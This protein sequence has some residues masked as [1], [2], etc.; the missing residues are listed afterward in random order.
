MRH[1]QQCNE[2]PLS[3]WIICQR[4]GEICCAH[5]NC[6]AG[7][8]EVCTH[9]AAV[10]F[11]LE[12]STRLNERNT[13]TQEKC[14]WV[15]PGFQKE[16]PYSPVKAIDFTSARGKKTK[17]DSVL[18]MA[19]EP[20]QMPV[21]TPSPSSNTAAVKSPDSCELRSLFQ[22]LSE[23]GT[24]PA[25]LSV[26]FPYANNYTPKSSQ[27]C[28]PQPLQTLFHQKYFKM[29]YIALLSACETFEISITDEMAQAVERETRA[30]SNSKLWFTFRA[31]RITASRMKSACC[32]DPANPAQS[33]VKVISYPEAFKFTTKL[34]LGDAS[35]KR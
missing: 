4:T 8:G 22:T 19:S 32:T 17:I 27:S 23:C 26:V 13:C 10:L 2:T 14:Q 34:L 5:C 25:V 9:V 21:S 29:D 33:L 15:V 11:F 7:L 30:Q 12:T 6:M 16:I 28:F 35:M 24:K 1:S 31:G 20:T 18:S 3:C